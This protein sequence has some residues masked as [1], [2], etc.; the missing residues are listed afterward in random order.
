MIYL[1]CVFVFL[2]QKRQLFERYNKIDGLMDMDNPFYKI[3]PYIM[4]YTFETKKRKKRLKV[5]EKKEGD[6]CRYRHRDRE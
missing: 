3:I 6:G 2:H 1:F 5:R 4:F